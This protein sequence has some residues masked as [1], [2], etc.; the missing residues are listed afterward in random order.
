MF[1]NRLLPR[2]TI[3]YTG[4]PTQSPS[5]RDR[6]RHHDPAKLLLLERAGAGMNRPRRSSS[7]T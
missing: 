3:R 4:S 7:W 1:G 2:M 5:H 6:A